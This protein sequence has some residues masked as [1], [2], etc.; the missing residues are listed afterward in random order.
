MQDSFCKVMVE[1]M[2]MQRPIVMTRIGAAEELIE[3]GVTGLLVPQGDAP[4]IARAIRTLINNPDLRRKMAEAGNHA[5][6]QRVDIRNTVL[7]T[8]QLYTRLMDR[9]YAPDPHYP[10]SM[11]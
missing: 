10:S 9:Q 3:N 11:G 8:E 5:V 1:A 7:Q 4:A 6:R 2:A